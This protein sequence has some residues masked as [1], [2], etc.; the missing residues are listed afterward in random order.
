[1][2]WVGDSVSS[3]ISNCLAGCDRAYL[4]C[5]SKDFMLRG[6]YLSQQKCILSAPVDMSVGMFLYRRA[7]APDMSYLWN[8]DHKGKC[9]GSFYI[10]QC[11]VSWTAQRAL[12]FLPPMTDLYIPT[13]FSASPGSILASEHGTHYHCCLHIMFWQIGNS[14]THVFLSGLE[15]YWHLFLPLSLFHRH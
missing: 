13:P 11:P 12:H 8:D 15:P 9:K 6:L 7:T 2:Q 3:L 4:C 14:V 5:C 10:A 1:M